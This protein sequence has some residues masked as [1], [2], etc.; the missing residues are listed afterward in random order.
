MEHT[1]GQ[2]LVR[3]IYVATEPGCFIALARAALEGK[4]V[5][6]EEL[7]FEKVRTQARN[8]KTEV[9][10]FRFTCKDHRINSFQTATGE[11]IANGG[12]Q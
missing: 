9:G 6:L 5:D 3:E 11:L 2:R 4:A 7:G 10:V 8:L 12:A 1:P